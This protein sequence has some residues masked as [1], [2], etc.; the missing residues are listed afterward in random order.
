[1]KKE[2]SL[3]TFLII[4]LNFGG[5]AQDMQHEVNP[6]AANLKWQ[7]DIPRVV[8]PN[9][10]L[11]ALYEKTWSIAAGRVRKGP[12]GI[13]ASPYMD[14][15][16]YDDQIW[17]WDGCFMTMFCKYAPNTFPGKQTLLNY[18]IP[19]HETGE[20]PL[21]I[22]LRD[23]PPLFAWVEYDLYKFTGDFNHANYVLNEKQLLQRHFI[24]FDTVS[25]GNV[26]T[27]VSPEYNPIFRNVVRSNAGKVIGYT[28]TGGASGM[29]N[30]VRGRGAGGFGNIMWIDAIC[31][32][33]LSALNIS[34]LYKSFGNKIEAGKW[35]AKYNELKQ[36]V[37]EMYWDEDDGFYYDVVIS[38]GKL[39][40]VKTMA[41]YWAL[42]SE[43][44]TPER[45]KRMV[46]TL[47]NE[48]Y[49]GTKYPFNSLSR[50]DEDFNVLQKG[51]YW[52]G[53]VWP[54]MVYMGVK[55]LEK[56][57]YQGLA[58]SLA[59]RFVNQQ[60]NTY[61]NPALNRK[62]LW[63][64]YSPFADEPS[65]EHGKQARPEFC[66]WSALGPISLFI[67]NMIGLRKVDALKHEIVWDIK[68][69]NGTHGIKGLY[70]AKTKTS[71]MYYNKTHKVVVSTNLPYTLILG[72]VR[73]KC[74]KGVNTFS[75]IPKLR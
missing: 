25:T 23:N 63:E 46:E 45:A 56:F 13:P 38:S 52:R 3:V 44:A 62:T 39:C 4:S 43:V 60:L 48:K 8:H 57:G 7:A 24:W 31:Q 75:F 53:G 19:I 10:K 18:L 27:K 61:N 12:K 40:K 64:V 33:A 72:D 2:I 55:G 49:F 11:V 9:K 22:H 15:N 51:D 28:W 41:S 5:N 21:R 30:T 29:D 71:L 54:P 6:D 74:K 35:M 69:E 50:D 67:E 73:L 16:C 66:G 1:M 37:N 58:D 59:A 32:Q 70:F 42:I 14:E 65:T 20:T 36:V 47:R 26:N 68:A 34:R 17:I